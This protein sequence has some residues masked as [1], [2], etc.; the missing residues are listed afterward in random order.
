[1]N[2][3]FTDINNYNGAFLYPNLQTKQDIQT[4]G[5]L[6]GC[7]TLE[8]GESVSIPI[9]FEYYNNG[10]IEGLNSITKGLYFD[11]RN[12]LF[13][14]PHHFMIHFTAKHNNAFSNYNYSSVQDMLLDDASNVD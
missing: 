4:D 6:D 3:L 9:E 2:G 13:T 12:S 10:N 7:K 11:L 5:K 8:V 1:M 14:E